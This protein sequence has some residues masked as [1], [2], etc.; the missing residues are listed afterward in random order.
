VHEVHKMNGNKKVVFIPHFIL[1]STSCKL[2]KFD[3][4]VCVHT[5]V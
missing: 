5:E 3:N 4:C 2:V 1:D